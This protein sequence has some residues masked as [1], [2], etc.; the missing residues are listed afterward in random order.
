MLLR[1]TIGRALHRQ[2]LE[3]PNRPESGPKRPSRKKLADIVGSSEEMQRV[4][5][6]IEKVAPGNHPVLILGE[7]GTGKELVARAIHSL[8]REPT[9]HL[10][11]SIAARWF[12]AHRERALRP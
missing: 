6:I 10:F 1:L 5:R 11:L 12:S 3:M 2:H 4:Y 9:I 7:S 8:R